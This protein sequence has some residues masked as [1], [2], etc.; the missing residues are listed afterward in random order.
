MST[1]KPER[2]RQED[3]GVDV[4][5]GVFEA[6]EDLEEGRTVSGEEL[7]EVLKF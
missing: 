3:G 7:D 4:P 6:I 5:V 1:P 2:D